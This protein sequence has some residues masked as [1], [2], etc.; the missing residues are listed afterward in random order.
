[1]LPAP[2]PVLV[3]VVGCL[4]LGDPDRDLDLEGARIVSGIDELVADAQE[5]AGDD[6]ALDEL[7]LFVWN[8]GALE[9]H[10]LAQ[11]GRLVLDLALLAFGKVMFIPRLDVG[12]LDAHGLDLLL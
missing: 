7:A 11:K 2:A 6:P 9:F 3:A 4:V 1:M 5:T 8:Q 12:R 10:P